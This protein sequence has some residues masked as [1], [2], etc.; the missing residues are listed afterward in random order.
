M[1]GLGKP[2][3][4]RPKNM[5][6]ELKIIVP[7]SRK[8]RNQF[9]LLPWEIYKGDPYWI[10]PLRMDQEELTGY[11]YNAFY[12]E[13][14]IQNFLALRNNKPVGRISA[15]LNVGHLNRYHDGIGFFGFFESI[16]DQ[17]V[18]DAL[19]EAA[20]QWLAQQGATKIRGPMNP[21]MNH[22]LGLLIDGFDSSPFFMMTYNPP[23]Y[24]KLIENIG[25]RKSQDLYS[26]WGQIEMLPKVREK[27]LVPCEKIIERYG[28]NVRYLRKKNF[29]EDVRLFL[30]IYN[31]S[32][33]N[34]WGF[35]PYSEAELTQTAASLRYLM[36]PELAVGVELDGQ[37]VGASFCL[38][39]YNPRI[40]AINGRLF[41]FGWYYLLRKKSEL[42]RIRIVST[43]VLP[44]YQ[45]MG[46]GLVLM[47]ALV[48]CALDWGIKEAEFSWVL[49]S[50]TYSRGSLEKGG[51]VRNKTYR[52]YDM[53]IE[54]PKQGK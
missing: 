34:T 32:L 8:E 47:N 48:P 35:V 46:L 10:P 12:I 3:Y 43:N 2:G 16:D 33:S 1:G 17:E 22:T 38:P 37:L 6:N 9:L 11:R 51:A 13:N 45:M 18:A 54:P 42:K 44:E 49:E 50:N 4:K 5:A 26:F 23:Y 29:A 28:V 14:R 36:V 20:L 40:K 21:S 27:W 7:K 15:I 52:V 41:P 31:R 53:P 19:F 30:D 39:D 24:E 25:L